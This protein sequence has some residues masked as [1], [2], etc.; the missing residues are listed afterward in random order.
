[1]HQARLA[2][3]ALVAATLVTLLVVAAGCSDD[4]APPPG[5]APPE[6]EGGD[7][8]PLRPVLLAELGDVATALV[9]VPGEDRLLVARRSGEVYVL[10]HHDDDGFRVPALAPEPLIDLSGVVTT[11]GER[12]L[13]D[14]AVA[15]EADAV[16][17]SYTDEEGTVTLSRFSY[18]SPGEPTVLAAVP[19]TFAGHNG[20]GLAWLDDHTLA[21]SLGDQDLT[22]TEPPA[23]QDPDGPYGRIVRI[24]VDEAADSPLGPEDLPER[25]L[26]FGLR[27]PWRIAVD[28]GG[29][30]L[31]IADVGGDEV[32]EVDVLPLDGLDGPPPN[33]GW[34]I[35][36][37]TRRTDHPG[38][39]PSPVVDPVLEREHAEDVCAIAGGVPLP[40]ALAPSVAGQFV[41]GDNCGGDLVALDVDT[42]ELTPVATVDGGVVA[43]DGGAHDDV[44]ALGLGGQVWRLDPAGWEVDDPATTPLDPPEEED[45]LDPGQALAPSERQA[46]C[47][48]RRAFELLRQINQQPAAYQDL[49]GRAASTFAGAVPDLPTVIDV[50]AL[51]QVVDAAVAV[52]E[53]TGWDTG[54]PAFQRLFDDV[55]AGAAPYQD[56][57][58]AT[59]TLT[60]YGSSC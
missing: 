30:R 42:G 43:L 57:P 54:A 22:T 37:G 48:A 9:P 32:E 52:G 4:P 3:R 39:E 18:P 44:Y 38:P 60:D 51:Q 19:H 23:A 20:G 5:A 49:A 31:L 13:L 56:F 6:D 11:D 55:T 58:E 15:A 29:D 12:G 8:L 50:A 35:F 33:Y 45:P 1:M 24:D 16:Y 14:L 41:L 10:D 28:E 47:D 46:V 2:R 53:T 59:S 40:E 27:N 25:T 17:A 36:E 21:W 7:Q 26:A 34:P